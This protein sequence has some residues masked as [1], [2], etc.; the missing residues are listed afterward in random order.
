MA[1]SSVM[2]A[3]GME[4]ARVGEHGR[5]IEPRKPCTRRLG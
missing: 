3:A 4:H 5:I 2:T 1:D